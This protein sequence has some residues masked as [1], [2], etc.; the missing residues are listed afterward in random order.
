MII[1]VHNKF[2][3]EGYLFVHYDTNYSEC[4]RNIAFNKFSD[5]EKLGQIIIYLLSAIVVNIVIK[6]G[7]MIYFI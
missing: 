3:I 7:F 2:C 6:S 4:K 5:M 1:V